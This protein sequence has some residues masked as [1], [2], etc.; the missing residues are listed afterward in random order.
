[1]VTVSAACPEVSLSEVM[2][3][4]LSARGLGSFFLEQPISV[5]RAVNTATAAQTRL[6][7]VLV[8]NSLSNL[9]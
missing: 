7:M 6:V 3:I 9:A 5:A 2:A 1:M 4:P 8:F